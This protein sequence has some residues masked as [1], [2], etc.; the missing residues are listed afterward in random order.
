VCW[1]LCGCALRVCVRVCISIKASGWQVAYLRQQQNLQIYSKRKKS[2]EGGQASFVG[3]LGRRGKGE[4]HRPKNGCTSGRTPRHH[5]RGREG[6]RPYFVVLLRKAGC[7]AG[8]VQ[9]A[10]KIKLGSLGRQQP[11][12]GCLAG[13]ATGREAAAKNGGG[14]SRVPRRSQM[15]HSRVRE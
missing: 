2:K 1:V 5:C 10:P 9:P 11:I 4:A 3:C 12:A 15:I 6:P 8:H 7:R 14:K 13:G